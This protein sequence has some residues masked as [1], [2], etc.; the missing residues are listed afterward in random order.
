MLSMVV[1]FLIFVIFAGAVVV[2]MSQEVNSVHND[3][4]SNRALVAADAGVRAMIVQIE[5]AVGKGAK[6]STISYTYP[7]AVGLPSVSYSAKIA[8]QWDPLSP[9]GHRYYLISSTGTVSNGHELQNRTVNVVVRA[10]STTTFGSASNYATNQFGIPVWYT[11]DQSFD[12]PVYDG[13][14][15]HVEYDSSKLN[16]IF[17]NTVQTPNIPK[18]VDLSGGSTAPPTG[19]TW[20]SIISGGAPAFSIGGNP[21]GLPVPQANV[22][23]ASEAFY[24]D[25]TSLTS[26]FPACGGASGGVCM[27]Q[28]LAETGG[29]STLST[30]IY[31]NGNATISGSSVGSVETLTVKG[32]FGTYLIAVDFGANTTTVTKVGSPLKPA[33]YSGVASGDNGTGVGNGAIFVNGDATIMLGSVIQGKYVLAVPDYNIDQKNITIAG[34]GSIMYNDPTKDELGLWAN[35]V[36]LT[37]TDSNITIQAAIIAGF[38]GESATSGGFYN[39]WCNAGNCKKGD[40]GTLTLLGSLMQNMRGALG[41][42]I[43]AGV[44]TGFDRHINYDGRLASNPPPFFPVTGNYDIIAW[45]DIGN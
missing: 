42:F 8:N 22:L 7:E 9:A 1:L 21:I 35:N 15:M 34:T 16:P 32:A 41:K 2:Q 18:W 24:G 27:N 12:G 37:T 45:D 44:H 31:V 20:N 43:S 6:P 40:Q 36:I 25:P 4:V 30:G 17:L 39:V 33:V 3:G 14:P 19:G 10:Q 28:A 38:P 26:N 11:P 23:V 13:G 5:E 29:G